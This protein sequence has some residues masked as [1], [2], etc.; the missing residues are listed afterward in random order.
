M[1]LPCALY[2][3]GGREAPKGPVTLTLWMNQAPAMN[4]AYQNLAEAYQKAHPEVKIALQ[5]FEYDAYIQTLQTA[6]PSGT[7]S[8]LIM[9]FGTWVKSYAERLSPVPQSVMTPAAA[10]DKFLA[11]TLGGYLFNDTLYGIPQ[12][13]NIEYGAMLL[14]STIAR[15]AGIDP[16]R[17]WKTWDDLIR[18]MKKTVKRDKGAMTRAG[19]GFTHKDGIAYTFLS[20]LKQYGGSPMNAQET[21]FTFNTDAGRKALLLMKRLV[22]EGLVDPVLFNEKENFAGDAFFGQNMAGAII[23]P[24]VIADFKA[25]F[26]DVAKAATY[27]QLPS[28]GDTPVFIAASG[29]GL[30]VSKKSPAQARAW[31]VVKYIAVDPKNALSWN[32][33]TATLPA[34]IE[35]TRPPASEALLSRYPYLA[36][37]IRLI[38]YGEYQ[39]HMPDSDA[40][41]YDILYEA[42]HKL[43]RGTASVDQTLVTIQTQSDATLKK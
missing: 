1:T 19:L 9:M 38:P 41:V 2:A 35:N 12:E 36:T 11:A 27:V 16:T 42:I 33:Q 43:L 26:P 23:G 4:A 3:R 29:W 30:T 13:F 8:D 39:G 40:V 22:S 7:E 28:I 25:D 24:W 31:D 5:T 18:D 37:H 10:K 34:L 32:V 6:F 20:L 14:N 15:E 17:P 21:A